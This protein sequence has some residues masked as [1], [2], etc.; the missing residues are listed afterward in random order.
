MRFVFFFPMIGAIIAGLIV[1]LT[2]AAS[3]SAPQ[4]ASGYAMACA[5][6]VV[7]YVFARA[8]QVLY[9]ESPAKLT[10]KVVEAIRTNSTS[11]RN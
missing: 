6:A 7:P 2:L 11:S 4:A 8:I 5:F 9:D 10:D 3:G 1:M